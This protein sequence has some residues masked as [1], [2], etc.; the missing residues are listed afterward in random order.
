[1]SMIGAPEV[2]NGK[3]RLV[4]RVQASEFVIQSLPVLSNMVTLND[5]LAKLSARIDE[6]SLK[7]DPN[8]SVL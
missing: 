6:R 2:R 8:Q 3:D 5:S 7:N 1:M 4:L